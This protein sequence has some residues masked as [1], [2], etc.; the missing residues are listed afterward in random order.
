MDIS[1]VYIGCYARDYWLARLCV[2]SVRHWYPEIR[3]SLIKD[4]CG[5]PF[6]TK[7]LEKDFQ[8]QIADTPPLMRN[9][10]RLEI[11]FKKRKERFLYLDAD[12]IMAGP[13][14][15]KLNQQPEEFVV[16]KQSKESYTTEEIESLYYSEQLIREQLDP[17]F[18]PPR[19]VFNSGQFV[20]TSGILTRED[21]ESL[22]DWNATPPRNK[23]P[24]ILALNDQG[25]LN[26]A[27]PKFSQCR[28][29]TLGHCEFQ[30]NGA[31][32]SLADDFPPSE[33]DKGHAFIVHWPGTKSLALKNFPN[34][35]LLRHYEQIFLDKTT[36]NRLSYK[37]HRL[38]EV[39][40]TSAF[41]SIKRLYAKLPE[42][43]K[44]PFRSLRRNSSQ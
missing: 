20:A 10:G 41:R 28:K 32:P 44:K 30:R 35:S 6:N 11:M 23:N 37:Y 2:A 1:H 33:Y 5:G 3:I 4:H 40:A 12:I 25:P 42:H 16:H 39:A 22:V 43:A 8:V 18:I 21:F 24:S 7:A 15:E 31:D 27:F 17:T 9:F 36:D 38:R 29:I 34:A 13:V 26:Y 14:I 19:E